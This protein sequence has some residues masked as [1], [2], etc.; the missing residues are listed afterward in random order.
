MIFFSN[1]ETHKIDSWQ[2]SSISW[3][4]WITCLQFNDWAIK[5][6]KWKSAWKYAWTYRKETPRRTWP[7]G[8][9]ATLQMRDRSYHHHHQYCCLEWKD[10]PL[11]FQ[12]HGT[13]CLASV[14]CF[15]PG[16]Y[17]RKFFMGRPRHEVQPLPFYVLFL[18]EKAPLSYTLYWQMVALLYTKFRPFRLILLL[19]MHCLLNTNKRHKTRTFSQFFHSRDLF[20]L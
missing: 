16:G 11:H 18:T 5:R 7:V 13:L 6:G 2:S 12:A 1:Q 8:E 4:S 15:L 14:V 9:E 17:S 10:C 3:D 19:K 20:V